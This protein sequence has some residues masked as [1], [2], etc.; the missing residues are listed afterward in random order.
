MVQEGTSYD[1]G[2]CKIIHLS[3][4]SRLAMSKCKEKPLL[5]ALHCI[6]N[7]NMY[8]P[9]WNHFSSEKYT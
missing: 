8:G 2:N 7:F 4:S 3:F 6:D 1:V 5:H 9:G